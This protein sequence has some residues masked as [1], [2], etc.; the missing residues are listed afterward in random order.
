MKR[1]KRFPRGREAFPRIACGH[2]ALRRWSDGA[3]P[4]DSSVK[5]FWPR[6]AAGAP[7]VGVQAPPLAPWARLPA[8][9]SSSANRARCAAQSPTWA[10]WRSFRSVTGWFA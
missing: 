8:W 4:G 5:R 7:G 9:A 2:A 10:T 3:I 1:L 6:P